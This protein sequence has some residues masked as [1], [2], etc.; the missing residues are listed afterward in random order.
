MHET[1][2]LLGET[3]VS[4]SETGT[5]R[6]KGE[7]LF[8]DFLSFDT[9]SRIRAQS[10]NLLLDVNCPMH[11]ICEMEIDIET[12]RT[13]EDWLRLFARLGL[14][15][16]KSLSSAQLHLKT[17]DWS[18]IGNNFFSKAYPPV[19]P[20]SRRDYER[21]LINLTHW[22]DQQKI[23]TPGEWD[24]EQ[25]ASLAGELL[26]RGTAPARR[27]RFYRRVWHALGLDPSVWNVPDA[28]SR[29]TTEEHYRRLTTR[30]VRRL[31]ATAR[32]RNADLADMIL[33]GY[34]T[35]LR[36]SD[37]AELDRG[38]VL[39]SRKALR[40]VPNKV[41]VRKPRPLLIPLVG[42]AETV[43]R[44]RMRETTCGALFPSS[45]SIHLS[46]RICRL[47]KAARVWK[48]GNGRASFHSLRA[49]FISLMDEAGIQPYITDAITG[50]ASGGMH[51][52]YTQPALAV[53]RRA[54][55]KAIPRVSD[56][57]SGTLILRVRQG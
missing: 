39:L 34:W 40:I 32:K 25:S 4:R 37:V 46:R 48:V 10:F 38:E 53:L 8:S 12:L 52:R 24:R 19:P 49:T 6:E 41:R 14:E 57:V 54:I 56:T 22:A 45:L 21:W 36:L 23:A 15:A 2:D 27:F 29:R 35:G 18:E 28:L 7:K 44:K 17:P 11:I 1:L 5:W 47:F 51:A 9:L 20:A 26:A 55:A 16:Q 3:R 31:L 30:E 50:H 42:D 43:V 13:R 33:I